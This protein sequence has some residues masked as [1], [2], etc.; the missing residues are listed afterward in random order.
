MEDLQGD[1][2]LGEDWYEWRGALRA[3]EEFRA[4]S[5]MDEVPTAVAPLAY[6]WRAPQALDDYDEELARAEVLR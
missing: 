1:D 4:P 2:M 3:A 5:D 6:G